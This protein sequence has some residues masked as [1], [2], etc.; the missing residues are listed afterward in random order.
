MGHAA[1]TL[2]SPVILFFLLGAVAAFLRSDLEV[3]EP[4][5]KGLSLYLMASI[6][7][8]GGMEVAHVGFDPRMLSTALAGLGLSFGLPFL[9]YPLLRRLGKLDPV[10]AGAIAA[11]YGSVS[12]VTFVTGVAALEA[13]GS[14]PAGW[15]VAVLALME[16]PA[17][18]SGL[19][20][21]RGTLGNLGR[22]RN[23]EGFGDHSV[24]R[25][26]LLNGPV[27][28]LVGSFAVGLLAPEEGLRQV[29]PLFSD[30]FRGALC[31]FLLSMGLLAARRLREARNLRPVHAALAI[32]LPLLN[33]AIG[34]AAARLLGLEPDTA[35]AFVILCASASYIA[36]PAAMQLAL[37]RADAG[38]YLAMSLAITFPFNILVGI[39]LYAGLA[40]RL[41]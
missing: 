27:V 31:L 38:L 33:A 10:D 11:H 8:R 37:P 18:V 19:L 39:P 2:L 5:A 34:L 21:A 30:L 15:M 22:A 6:G 36:V 4:V 12:V 3:P 7:L 40:H 29:T 9:G 41:S 16:T 20:L 17:I 26:V 35:A 1:S 28:L 14:G 24:W 13:D 23:V 32:A 25:E